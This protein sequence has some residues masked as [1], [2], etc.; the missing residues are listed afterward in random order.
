VTVILDVRL[1][2]ALEI[3]DAAATDSLFESRTPLSALYL[4]PLEKTE[5]VLNFLY[6]L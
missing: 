4:C 5:M 1:V 2:V 6:L 3:F